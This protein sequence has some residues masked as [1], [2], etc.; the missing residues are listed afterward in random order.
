MD[1]GYTVPGRLRLPLSVLKGSRARALEAA[2]LARA[3][4]G[5]ESAEVNPT[6]GSLLIYHD[7]QSVT[8]E[9]LLGV[10]R[11]HHCIGPTDRLTGRRRFTPAPS[12]ISL[13]ARVAF[14]A[15]VSA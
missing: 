12:I 11:A 15:L 8:T 3:V 13:L 14:V 6:T 10:L 4:P 1:C 2:T 5:V 7:P 9:T